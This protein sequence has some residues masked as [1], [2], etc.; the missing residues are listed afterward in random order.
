[1]PGAPEIYFAK[2]QVGSPEAALAPPPRKRS[3]MATWAALGLVLL[4]LIGGGV[5]YYQQHAHEQGASQPGNKPVAAAR[6]DNPWEVVEE[7]PATQPSGKGPATKGDIFDAVAAPPGMALV[8]GGTFTMGRSI[9]P[10]LEEKPAHLVTV[11]S[12]YMDV[13]PQKAASGLPLTGVSWYEAQQKCQAEGKRLPT[14]AE[15]EFAARGSDGRL[16]PWGDTFDASAAN[17]KEAGGDRLVPVGSLPKNKSPFGVL[18]MSGNIWEWTADAYKPYPGGKSALKIPAD[19]KAIR[20]G[21]SKSDRLHVTTTTR[22]LEHASKRS[23]V[24]G[25]RCAK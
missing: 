6:A 1:M 7:K 25:F 22:N 23:P 3:G 13:L 24:I 9:G 12:F 14:E 15:W 16:Y 2:A 4:F 19:A 17:S 5:W 18:E 21:S 20:G 10:D 8:P 11:A